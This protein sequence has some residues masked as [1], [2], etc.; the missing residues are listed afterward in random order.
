[1]RAPCVNGA[2]APSSQAVSHRLRRH[3]AYATPARYVLGFAMRRGTTAADS[4]ATNGFPAVDPSRFA[5]TA[6]AAESL[7][8][9]L[10]AEF[11]FGVD[12]I[13]TGL[14]QIRPSGH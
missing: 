2:W 14:A 11:T 4:A 13:I 5:A 1:M 9:R 3:V 6:A 7:P 10:D 12:L 8:V